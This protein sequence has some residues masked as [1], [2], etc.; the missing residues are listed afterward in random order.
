LF[1]P[2]RGA[3][4]HTSRLTRVTVAAVTA[5]ALAAPPASARWATETEPG[6]S[7]PAPK[8]PTVVRIDQGFDTGSAALGA[9]G[10]AGI[11]LLC[12]AGGTALVRHHRRPGAVS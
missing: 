6:G 3:T 10:A 9:G 1:T 12:L 8:G 4:V 5:A 11:V 7:L 2:P